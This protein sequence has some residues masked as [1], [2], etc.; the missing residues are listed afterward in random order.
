MCARRRRQAPSSGKPPTHTGAWFGGC[1][2]SCHSAKEIDFRLVTSIIA[3]TLFID[4][5]MAGWLRR[6]IMKRSCQHRLHATANCH[7][8]GKYDFQSL[9]D[10]CHMKQCNVG[11]GKEHEP[12]IHHAYGMLVCPFEERVPLAR[13]CELLYFC[14]GSRGRSSPLLLRVPQLAHWC[15]CMYLK[16]ALG[17]AFLLMCI[18]S[19]F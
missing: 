18:C 13:C 4:R 11:V 14:C 6:N 10:C 5:S 7:N 1:F 12:I 3:S 9:S 16:R 19:R 8:S 15:K 2:C 17:A